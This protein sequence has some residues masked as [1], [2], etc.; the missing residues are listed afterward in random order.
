MG[1]ARADFSV[2]AA[3]ISTGVSVAIGL[4]F[5]IHPARQAATLEPIAALRTRE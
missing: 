1:W 4:V 3:M 5:G 2:D